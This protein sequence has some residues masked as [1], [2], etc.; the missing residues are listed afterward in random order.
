[1]PA[2]LRQY[3]IHITDVNAFKQCRRAW[4]WSSSLRA[5]LAPKERYQPYYLG[6]L[7]HF[8][9]EM[10]YRFNTPANQAIYSYL[11]AA[12]SF[13]VPYD[14]IIASVPPAEL[15]T[16]NLATG[17]L[18]HYAL[19]QQYDQTWLA[20][21]EFDFIAPEQ[22]FKR[23]LWKN[24]RRAIYHAGRYD[25][26]VL[27]RATGKYYLWEI[28][29]TRSLSERTKQ[30]TFD[31]QTD[32]YLLAAQE[33]LDKPIE[34]I[35]YTLLRKKLPENPKVLA[36]NMLSTNVRVDTT[37]EHF[38]DFANTHHAHLALDARKATIATNYSDVIQGLL[39]Q[40]NKYFAR[41]LVQRSQ[42]ALEISSTELK[43]VAQAMIDR[44][45]PIY[46][47]DGPH[48]L[49]CSFRVPC[50]MMR[51]GDDYQSYLAALYTRKDQGNEETNDQ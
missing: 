39:N 20:D 25:G 26:I 10:K 38:L 34:G 6:T 7:V 49:Y 41:I 11:E 42:R 5:N 23:V 16:I 33:V 43:Q 9:L 12:T 37:P 46:A 18:N 40:P 1:M 22:D 13:E 32:T 2:R 14:Q 45:T 24:T 44:R 3:S 35:I 4:N 21:A 47:S 31:A 50:T 19:W 48:C 17:M 8:G 36:N 15:D 29:T 27:H 30:L 28:K 51:N